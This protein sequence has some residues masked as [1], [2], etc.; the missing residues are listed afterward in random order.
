MGIRAGDRGRKQAVVDARIALID[1]GVHIWQNQ[2]IST[3]IKL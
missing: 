1:P 2:F 3:V